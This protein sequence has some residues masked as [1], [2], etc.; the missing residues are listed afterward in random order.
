M[1]TMLAPFGLVVSSLK[2]ALAR[3]PTLIPPRRTPP[4]DRASA[5]PPGSAVRRPAGSPPPAGGGLPQ[6]GGRELV[7]PDRHQVG[8]LPVGRGEQ[9]YRQPIVEGNRCLR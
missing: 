5:T 7:C 3:S 2:L 4:A 8:E 6:A 1:K 9:R